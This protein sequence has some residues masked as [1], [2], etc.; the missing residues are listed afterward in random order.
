MQEREDYPVGVPCYVDTGRKDPS[1]AIEFY[2]GLFGWEFENVSPDGHPAYYT[3]TL[4]GLLVAG[5]GEQPDMEWAPVWNTYVRVED[6]DAS[7]AKVSE[8]GG[9]VTMPPFEIGPAGRMAAFDDPEG[10]ALCIL[11]PGQTRGSQLVNDPGAWV[12]STLHTGDREGAEAFYGA[13]FGWTVGPA[14]EDGSA[15]VMKPGYKDFLAQKDPELPAR[16]EQLGAPEGFGDVVA[17]TMPASDGASPHWDVTFSVEDAD[18]SVARVS[19]LGGEVLVDPFDAPW[20][21]AAVVRDAEG[22][23]FTVSQFVPPDS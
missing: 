20:V 2:G 15:M 13:V 12:F 11:E 17:T 9:K 8:S 5:L 4:N 14:D 21:R 1:S 23:Q 16:H 19:E 6:A 18:A 10:A 3:A 22:V 7:A